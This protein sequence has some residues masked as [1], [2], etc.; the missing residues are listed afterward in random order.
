MKRIFDLNRSDLDHMTKEE[1]LLSMALAEG[2]TL[3]TEV[4]S[5]VRPTLWD[6]S[7]PELA[8]AFGSDFILL[9]TYNLDRPYIEGLDKEE[10]LS[11]IDKVKKYTGLMVGINLEPVD[12]EAGD[13][14]NRLDIDRGRWASRENVKKAID[15]GADLVLL[16]GNPATGVKSQKIVEAVDMIAREFKD[17]I[18]IAAGKMHGSGSLLESGENIVKKENVDEFIET[19]ADIILLPC[20]GTVPGI[21]IDYLRELVGHIHK[22]GRLAMTSIGTSQEGADEETIRRLAIYA[23]MTGTDLHHIGDCGMPPGMASLENIL[24]YSIA[25]RGKRHS[26][27][28]MARS[29]ER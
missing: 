8:K 3:V 13:V 2:R 4:I 29:I 9:N 18:I 26:Y 28:R 19:G 7:N 15:Q 23:K 21:G 11:P 25:I 22:R 16:T 17:Q 5:S 1:K 12:L 14:I 6:I 24:A 10:G 27:R 20:P